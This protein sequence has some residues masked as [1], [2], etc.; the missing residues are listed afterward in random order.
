MTGTFDRSGSAVNPLSALAFAGL[1]VWDGV[2]LADHA[3]D[4][5]FDPCVDFRFGFVGCEPQAGD[6]WA[7]RRQRPIVEE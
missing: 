2:S 7:Q 6:C 1:V 5:S 3:F 4:E